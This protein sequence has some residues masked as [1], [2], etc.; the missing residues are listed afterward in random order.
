MSIVY[1]FA[2][3]RIK[4]DGLHLNPIMPKEWKR[5]C[6]RIYYQQALITITMAEKL[7]IETTKPIE[8][9]V[10]HKAYTIDD[11]IHLEYE[12]TSK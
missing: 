6:F 3:L 1:G 8:V 7:T 2:G 11:E 4:E 12:V 10:N 5:I 9:V